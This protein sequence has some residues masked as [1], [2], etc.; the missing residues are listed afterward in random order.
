[1]EGPIVMVGLAHRETDSFSSLSSLEALRLPGHCMWE[2]Q[3]S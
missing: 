1:M 2:S 3:T